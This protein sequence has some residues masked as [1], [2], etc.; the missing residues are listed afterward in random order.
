MRDLIN[1]NRRTAQ[2]RIREALEALSQ[3]VGEP[4]DH[5]KKG[6][7]PVGRHGRRVVAITEW[8]TDAQLAP[9]DIEGR[10]H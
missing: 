5:S 3:A 7:D 2:Q 4:A 10:K 9:V 8:V 1:R 6:S